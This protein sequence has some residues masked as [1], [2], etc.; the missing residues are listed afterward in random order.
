M[1]H[2]DPPGWGGAGDQLV[3]MMVMRSCVGGPV[4]MRAPFCLTGEP[5]SGRGRIQSGQRFNL[6]DKG[7]SLTKINLTRNRIILLLRHFVKTP[8]WIIDKQQQTL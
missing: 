1:L 3:E 4:V 8:E 5:R 6:I 2:G 7:K